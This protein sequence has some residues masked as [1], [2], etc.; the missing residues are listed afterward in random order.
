MSAGDKFAKAGKIISTGGL[1]Q[2]KGIKARRAGRKEKRKAKEARGAARKNDN[3]ALGGSVE[4]EKRLFAE[5]QANSAES[6]A[7][8][9]QAFGTAQE[10]LGDTR[11][12]QAGASQDYQADRGQSLVRD[13][14]AYDA[15]DGIKQSAT[16]GQD[17]V[18]RAGA[19]AADE[20]T[21]G[22]QQGINTRNNA[23]ATNSLA[24]TAE[25]VL[26]QRSSDLAGAPSITAMNEDNILANQANAQAQQQRSTQMLNRQ[27]M[28][29]AAGQGEGGA[30]AMQQAMASAGAGAADLAAA[31]NAQ[32]AEST[33]ASRYGASQAQRG[34]LVDTANLGLTTRM[35]AAEQ[36]RANQMGV[37]GANAASLEGAAGNR[38]TTG[39]QV[40][41]SQAGMGINAAA[42]DQAARAQA[43]QQAAARTAQSNGTNLQ[44]Q[45]Q[46]A[47]L[48]AG[49]ANTAL[50]GETADQGYQADIMTA[51]YGAQKD[52]E[53]GK[54]RT[55]AQKVLMPFGVL[56]Q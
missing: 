26:A 15:I 51:K 20:Y 7:R 48:A 27:A 23:L 28:G 6:R 35:G 54:E 43:A 13:Q 49:N 9:N 42:A 32:L 47:N 2:L 29:L 41:G 38:A 56:G 11:R 12:A 1:S 46:R 19:S 31:K 3:L 55:L 45:A 4:E 21:Q 16:T 10:E 37:A 34:E 24:G 17:L 18:G 25:G 40:A 44:L 52:R 30:L 22:A 53:D 33:A 5:S 14:Q 36:E 8:A 39:L 50:S